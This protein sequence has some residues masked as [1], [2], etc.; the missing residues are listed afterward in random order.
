MHLD[1]YRNA[2]IS[3]NQHQRLSMYHEMKKKEKMIL[4]TPP[5]QEPEFG[6]D[7]QHGDYDDGDQHEHDYP[8]DGLFF[9]AM[10]PVHLGE[11]LVQ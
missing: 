10:P 4:M 3:M 11:F 2:K 6:C 7:P 9:H 5:E 1:T 8:G